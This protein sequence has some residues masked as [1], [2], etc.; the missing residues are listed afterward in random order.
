MA[1]GVQIRG[2]GKVLKNFQNFSAEIRIEAQQ[3]LVA[4][5]MIE[6]ETVAKEKLTQD[7]HIDTGRL[8]ASIFTKTKDNKKHRYSDMEGKSYT[9]NLN[10]AVDNLQV[11]V[12]T[13]VEYAR[14]IERLDSYILYAY[15]QGYP[16]ILKNMNKMLERVCNRYG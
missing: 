4:S 5:C 11:V 12:G 8:R 1:N 14:K 2:L 16:K 13:D 10:K 9:C 3:E 6:L 7:H 15:K